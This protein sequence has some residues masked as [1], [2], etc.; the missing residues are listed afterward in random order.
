MKE[1]KKY[2]LKCKVSEGMFSNEKLVSFQD[3]N[4]REISGFWPSDCTKNGLLEVRVAETGKNKSLIFG[5]F[6]DCG[7][8]GFFPGRGFYVTNDLLSCE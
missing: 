2:Y 7:G 6:T 8:Y 3:I 1:A 4:N 5:P